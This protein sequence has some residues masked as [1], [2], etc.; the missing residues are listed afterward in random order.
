MKSPP[1]MQTA[2][3][4][5][6][7]STRAFPSFR[8]CTSERTCPRSLASSPSFLPFVL[9][10][11]LLASSALASVQGKV[12]LLGTPRDPDVPIPTAS[13]PACGHGNLTTE[14]WKIG[15]GN[16]LADTVVWVQDGPAGKPNP[17]AKAVIDQK[18]CRYIPH[19]LCI[20][21]GTTVTFKNDDQ[22]LHNVHGM[23]YLGK[24]ENSV[25]IFNLGQ[26]AGM[27]TGQTFDTAGIFKIK[28]DV[29]SWMLGWII[30]TES[31]F[32]AVTGADGSFQ[33]P[34]LPDGSY[35]AQAWH[36]GFD[37]PLVQNFVVKGGN[38]TLDFQFNAALAD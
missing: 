8:S 26:I 19:V 16:G 33:F 3:Q 38:A 37:K 17:D 14:N 36:S 31:R 2:G 28:C 32:F 1:R 27:A 23:Q 4:R 7:A 18:G 29:H 30:V 35:H 5:D 24:N 20:P 10:L 25:D 9:T 34:P 12:T 13:D 15:P 6:N 22:T 21:K 11:L